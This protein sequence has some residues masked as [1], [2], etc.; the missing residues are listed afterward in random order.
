MILA[1]DVGGTSTR[2]GLFEAAGPRLRSVVEETFHSRDHAGLEEIVLAVLAAKGAKPAH[3]AFGIAGPV[4]QGVVRTPN[5]PWVVEAA[6]VAADLG[7]GEVLLLNDLEANA[8]GVW[9]LTQ[10]DFAVLNAGA[11]GASGNAAIIAAGTGLGEAGFYWDGLRHHPFACEGGH[12]DFAPRN[13][14][15]VQLLLYLQKKIDHVSI[16]RVLSGPGLH[17]VYEFLRDTGRG[18]EEPRVR[19][20]MRHEDPSAV[21]SLEGLAGT[22]PLCVQALDIFVSVY[23]AEAGNLAL[24]I[25]A[26]GGLYVGGGIAPKVL[27][28]LQGRAFLEAFVSKGRMRFLLEAIPVRVI[29]N[30]KTALLGAARFA[31]LHAGL[32][33]P[34]ALG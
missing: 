33:A 26:T 24:K 34:S 14:V 3:A 23:G 2:L 6:R 17:A 19:E 4:R 13:D 27:P 1:G 8:H 18:Q 31:A 20:R 12:V 30:D 10:A 21:V 25:L 11:A 22:C 16:E 5:L 7:L 28:K 15:E 29:L 9:E 32:L